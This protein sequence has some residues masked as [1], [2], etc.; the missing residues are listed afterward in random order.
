[1]LALEAVELLAALATAPELDEVV[2][3]QATVDRGARGDDLPA[4]PGELMLEA[5]RAPAR[6]L[7]TQL[8]DLRLD[9]GR[10]LMGTVRRP[11]ERSASAARP[12]IS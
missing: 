3:L 5:P 9:L 1:V 7:A 12:P 6:V 4:P 2:A 8:T 11:W 10:D